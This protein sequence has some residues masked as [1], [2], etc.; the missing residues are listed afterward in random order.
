MLPLAWWWGIATNGNILTITPFVDLLCF[1][2]ALT[3]NR[4]NWEINTH[5]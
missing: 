1:E 5:N 3:I 2:I 4:T